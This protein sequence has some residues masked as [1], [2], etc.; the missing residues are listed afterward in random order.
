MITL[1][2]VWLLIYPDGTIKAETD[3]P[4]T[5][6]AW[7]IDSPAGR[8]V[9]GTSSPKL[10]VPPGCGLRTIRV[11]LG[12]DWSEPSRSFVSQPLDGDGDYDGT[13]G[14]QDYLVLSRNYAQ[15]C[16]P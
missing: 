6:W 9:I 10:T 14:I 2:I 5:T 12:Q 7:A 13:V 16:Q 3:A 1:A 11:W 4:G 8:V 15:V